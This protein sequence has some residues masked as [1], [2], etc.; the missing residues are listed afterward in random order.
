ML[1]SLGFFVACILVMVLAPIYRRRAD[2][3]ASERVRAVLPVTLEEIRA[4]KDTIRAKHAV[5]IHGLEKHLEDARLN[6]ARQR[7][8]LNRRD[9]LICGLEEQVAK[10]NNQLDEHINARRVLE[11]NLSDRLPRV[12]E[13]LERAQYLIDQR[14]DEIEDLQSGTQRGRRALDEALQVNAQQRAELERLH[15][16]MAS[17]RSLPRHADLGAR[18]DSETA[19]RS[20]LETL[21]TRARDQAQIITRLQDLLGKYDDNAGTNESR[22]GKDDARAS[23]PKMVESSDVEDIRR[24]LSEAR[25]TLKLARLDQTEDETKVIQSSLRAQ[26]IDAL[27]LKAKVEEQETEIK[28]L[29]AELD[30]LKGDGNGQDGIGI[31]EGSPIAQKARLNALQAKLN[32]QDEAIKRLRAELV[33]SNERLARQAMQHHDEM[34]RLG[35]GTRPAGSHMQVTAGQRPAPKLVDKIVTQTGPSSGT[36]PVSKQTSPGSEKPA[37]VQVKKRAKVAEFLNIFHD[38]GAKPSGDDA[39][40]AEKTDTGTVG[41]A[42]RDKASKKSES[43]SARASKAKQKGQ[44]SESSESG[45]SSESAEIG[46]KKTKTKLVDRIAGLERN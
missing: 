28:S 8:E 1:I 22:E 12:T 6:A 39:A 33:A 31:S 7:V 16:A 29:K 45:E 2:R 20:E 46:D 23:G 38:G 10:L 21:R 9:A 17:A 43:R 35:G 32:S 24:D 14:D 13:R 27:T 3:L 4:D 41:E 19:L 11:H 30:T 40:A 36:G 18:T 5:E 37:N 15:A 25:A 34:R 44:A 42:G 26:P